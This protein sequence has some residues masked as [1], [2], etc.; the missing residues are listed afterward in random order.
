MLFRLLSASSQ[1]SEL[2]EE[3]TSTPWFFWVVVGALAV[4]FAVMIVRNFIIKKEE[5]YK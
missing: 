2:A 4:G 1:T 3:T 5:Y